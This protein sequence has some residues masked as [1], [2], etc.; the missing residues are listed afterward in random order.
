MTLCDSS[1][2]LRVSSYFLFVTQRDT[3]KTQSDTEKS[4]LIKKS[5]ILQQIPQIDDKGQGVK[6]TYWHLWPT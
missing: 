5:L 3:E 2:E 1:V 4:I 6:T